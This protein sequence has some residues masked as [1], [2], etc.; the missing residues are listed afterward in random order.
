[1]KIHSIFLFALAVIGL[2]A[3]KPKEKL[4]EESAAQG[5]VQT[6]TNSV[7]S[8][9][10]QKKEMNPK[11]A[12]SQEPS[13][14]LKRHWVSFYS[15]GGGIESQ[16]ADQFNSLLQKMEAENRVKVERVPW[17]REGEVDF[18]IELV[19][20]NAELKRETLREIQEKLREAKRVHQKV[21]GECRRRGR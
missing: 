14:T 8:P 6:T 11:T 2:N 21:N 7:S 12:T 4:T 10:S 15:I 13:D 16:L 5:T 18:C 19:S 20:K 1:M 9:P 3:C 17:G